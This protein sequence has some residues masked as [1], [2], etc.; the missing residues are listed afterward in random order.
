MGLNGAKVMMYRF[1]LLCVFWHVAFATNIDPKTCHPL[2]D[3]IFQVERL[4]CKFGGRSDTFVFDGTK[5][6][7]VKMIVLDVFSS[8][9]NLIVKC[10][11]QCHLTLV[12]I[13]NGDCSLQEQV[14]VVGSRTN[15]GLEI[16]GQNCVCIR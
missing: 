2:Y 13:E 8:S 4:Q 5:L 14:T 10:L 15:I 6:S 9:S 12:R 1:A 3:D 16:G 7:T 11:G